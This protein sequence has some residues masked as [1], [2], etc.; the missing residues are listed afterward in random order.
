VEEADPGR[1]KENWQSPLAEDCWYRLVYC[2][3]CGYFVGDVAW[4]KQND[5]DGLLWLMIKG[6]LRGSG[7]GSAVLKHTAKT[8]KDTLKTFTVILPP[9][10]PDLS[11]FTNR[12]FIPVEETKEQITLQ[13]ETGT[14]AR[15]HSSDCCSKEK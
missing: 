11:F 5:T 13:A 6:D 9:N 14:L 12:G 15:C 7:Y 10:H 4:K 1:W 3:A 2:D 8:F